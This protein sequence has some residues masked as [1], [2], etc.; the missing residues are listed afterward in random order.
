MAESGPAETLATRSCSG[1]GIIAGKLMLAG[2]YAVLRGRAPAISMAVGELVRWRLHDPDDAPALTMTAFDT[3]CRQPM[4]TVS[5]EGLWRLAGRVLEHLRTLGMTL[6]Q[7][8][9]LEVKGHVQGRKLG[10]GTSSAVTLALLQ[11]A[12][13]DAGQK[14]SRAWLIEQGLAIH[15]AAQGGRGSGY[16]IATQASGGVIAYRQ[17]PAEIEVL[18]WP[19]G[20]HAAA[21]WTG[22]PA[23]TTSALRR[24]VQHDEAA[25]AAIA[26]RAETLLRH[27]RSGEA[28]EV[29]SALAACEA[30]FARLSAV[31]KHLVPDT[32]HALADLIGEHGAVARTS[33][34]GGGDCLLA[35]ATSESTID[36]VVAAWRAD[37]GRCV[38]RM[39]VDI[40]QVGEA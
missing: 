8:V 30:A 11:A 18:P 24:G 19:K 1:H 21:L 40:Q 3:T 2:E 20:L 27:W 7:S 15:G 4:A 23:D 12:L 9:T 22:T 29:L 37:A 33:G 38:A 35:V 39:P 31:H 25:M 13:R 28:N 36:A 16:D 5:G 6:R 34:A 10:L 17:P 14:N 26:D 32:A